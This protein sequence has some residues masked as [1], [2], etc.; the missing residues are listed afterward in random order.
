LL[1]QSTVGDATAR[2]ETCGKNSDKDQ[3]EL[4]P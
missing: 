3:I 4:K 1:L 2:G